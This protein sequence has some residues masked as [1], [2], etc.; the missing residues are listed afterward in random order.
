MK[1]KKER[2]YKKKIKKNQVIKMI[3]KNQS[4]PQKMEEFRKNSYKTFQNKKMR[5][6]KMKTRSIFKT[7]TKL[8]FLCFN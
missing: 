4:V 5:E 3:K 6:K 7:F 2:I 1:T 8:C